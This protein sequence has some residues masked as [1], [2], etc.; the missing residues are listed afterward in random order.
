[1]VPIEDA[2]L[3]IPKARADELRWKVTSTWEIK[4]SE[5]KTERQ[6]LKSL[7]IDNSI[8]ILPADKGNAT[9]VM[10]RV[11]YSNKLV[12]LIGYCKVKKDPTLKTER[13]LSHILGKNNDLIPQTKY[14]PLIQHYS[15]LPH[16]YGLPKIH[17]DGIPLRP[18]VSNRGWACH[19]L[20]HVFVEIISPLTGKSSSYV[21]NSIH[22]VERISDAPIHSNQMV[23]LD[24]V[25]L[26]TK[27]PT[28]ETLAVVLEKLDTDP[29]PEEHTCIPIDN[30]MEMLTFFVETTYFGKGSD[31]YCQEEGLAMGS[32]LSPLL[33]NIYMEYF[34]EMALGSTSLKPSMRL[35]YV[36]DTFILWPHQED[37]QILLDHENSIQPSKQFTMEKELDNKLPFLNVLVT[38]TEQGFRSSMYCKPTFTGQYLNFNSHR[39]FTVKKGIVYCL[40]HQAKTISSDTDAYQEEMISL[41]Y[42]LHHN[43]YPE[44]I[45]SAQRN[46]DRRI[47]DNTQK[48]ITVCLLYVKGLA[49][50]IQKICSP[51][52]IRTVFT[53]GSTLRR[54]N[55]PG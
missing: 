55:I 43:N 49:E 11:E 25:S 16:I 27:V 26:F 19:P 36:N 17:K 12:D 14:R 35:R 38:R 20:S 33:A 23:S 13:K 30:Q 22:F 37:V 50:R 40:Q 24:V 53:S 15:K 51:Y 2:A 10:D 29:L 5:T 28:D 31:I 3:K 21:K 42:N 39:P 52:D 7:Q 48:L 6:A 9:L 44:H 45:T 8:I 46:L 4:A 41:R 54:Y 34:E 32:P 47:E 18:I 1:M